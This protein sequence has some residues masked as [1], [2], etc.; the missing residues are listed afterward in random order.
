MFHLRMPASPTFRTAMTIASILAPALSYAGAISGPAPVDVMIVGVFHMSNPGHD[1]HNMAVDD[2]LSPRRQTEISSLVGAL[3][4]FKP[5]K[6]GIEWSEDVVEERYPRYLAGTLPPSRNESVQLGFRLAK[7]AGAKAIYGLDA[8]GDFPYQPVQDYAA[9]HGF[10]GILDAQNAAIDRRLAEDSRLLAD[11]GLSAALRGINDPERLATDNAFYRSALRIG[12]GADQPGV[13]LLSAWYRR[14][15]LVCAKLLQSTQPGDRIVVFFGAGHAF[16]L[17]QCVA[18]TPG[19]R[20]VEPND[21][22][23]R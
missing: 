17:R 16:L 4:R 12:A 14:N 2:V 22:L 10:S 11:K 7:V 18:E 15:F 1:L 9:S 13:D 19:Y 8:D 20:L 21:Y 6:V 5:N 3:A 23:P